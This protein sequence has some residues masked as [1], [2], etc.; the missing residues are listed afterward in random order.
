MIDH[1]MVQ[2]TT[3]TQYMLLANNL[4]EKIASGVYPA[5]TL[6]P[7]EATLCEQFDVSRI[8][9]RGALKELETRG[10]VTRRAGIGTRVLPPRPQAA[11]THMGGSVD[12]VLRFT[13]GFPVHVIERVE[14]VATGELARE[15]ELQP[16]RGYVRFKTLRFQQDGKPMVFSHHHVPALHA[17]AS[18]DL[19]GVGESI[20]QWLA[21]RSGDAVCVIRQKIGAVALAGEEAVRLLREPGAPSLYSRRWYLG[22]QETLLLLSVSWFPAEIYTLDSTLRRGGGAS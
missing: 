1:T 12:E 16:G 20:A 7:S 4:T 18:E 3:G 2:R 5:G 11:F 13:S 9:V 21:D 10:L 8:T 14:F 19:E 6:I 15:L 17:P 22:K